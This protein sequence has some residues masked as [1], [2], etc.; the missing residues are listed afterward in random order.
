M[1]RC[2]VFTF[3]CCLVVQ[4][5]VFCCVRHY[6]LVQICYFREKT[7]RSFFTAKMKEKVLDKKNLTSFL[8]KE[9]FEHKQQQSMYCL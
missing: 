7:H 1:K 3:S 6:K 5:T 8:T 2:I 4:N 9:A